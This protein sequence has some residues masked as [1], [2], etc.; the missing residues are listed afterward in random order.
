M[1]T[2]VPY[3]NEVWENRKDRNVARE[4]EAIG[5]IPPQ[6]SKQIHGTWVDLLL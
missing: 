1:P 2:H 4:C 6:N 5:L 3:L